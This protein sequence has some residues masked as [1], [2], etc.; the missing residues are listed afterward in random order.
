MECSKNEKYTGPG[1]RAGFGALMLLINV[2]SE[3]PR[4]HSLVVKGS[5]SKEEKRGKE[6]EK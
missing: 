3:D 4:S 2:L 6:K 1:R 5:K